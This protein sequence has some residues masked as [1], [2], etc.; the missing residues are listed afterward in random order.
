MEDRIGEMGQWV[1]VLATN[2]NDLSSVPGTR[3]VEGGNLSSLQVVHWLYICIHTL[4][5]KAFFFNFGKEIYMEGFVFSCPRP[6][7]Q[8][9]GGVTVQLFPWSLFP[10]LLLE[11]KTRAEKWF[12]FSS[13]RLQ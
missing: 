4:K 8:P 6:S 10:P 7:P 2:L 11:G 1:K 9:S 3:M 5:K 12:L 13:E